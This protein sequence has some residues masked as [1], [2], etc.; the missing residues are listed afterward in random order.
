MFSVAICDDYSHDHMLLIEASR[1]YFRE[2]GIDAEVFGFD[3][4]EELLKEPSFELYLL[5]V[6]MPGMDGLEAA[7]HLRRRNPQVAVVFI[8][9]SIEFAVSG[10]MVDAV[11]FIVKPLDYDGFCKVMDRVMKKLHKVQAPCITLNINRT[12][13]QMP[14]D[15]ILYLESR[16]HNSII[17][18]TNGESVPL[19]RKLSELTEMLKNYKSFVQCHKSYVVN[20]EQVDSINGYSFIL[21]GGILVPISRSAYSESKAAYYKMKLGGK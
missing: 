13:V 3:N 11:G 14:V 16:L 20:L 7:E 21:A 1:R 5:D 10:Y 8:S 15:S 12:E 6:V 19:Y 9:S 4:A 17:H 18:L 2:K